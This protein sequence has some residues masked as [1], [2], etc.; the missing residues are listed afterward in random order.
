MI[1]CTDVCELRS[2]FALPPAESNLVK[3]LLTVII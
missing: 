3:Y 2:A 1:V